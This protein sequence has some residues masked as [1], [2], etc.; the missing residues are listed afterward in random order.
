MKSLSLKS[1]LFTFAFTA[2]GLITNAQNFEGGVRIGATGSTVQDVPLVESRNAPGGI[3]GIY[4]RYGGRFYGELGIMYYNSKTTF[5]EEFFNTSYD[6]DFSSVNVPILAGYNIIDN[7][8]FRLRAFAGGSL[9]FM[10]GIDANGLLELDDLNDFYGLLN[11]GAGVEYKK[12]HFD[13]KYEQAFDD[14]FAIEQGQ[15]MRFT[16]SIGY[17]IF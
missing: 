7:G 6:L 11:I 4:G 3:F 2:L 5:E 1:L 17:R 12:F 15:L 9:Q 10:T 14:F 16:G 13:F 8:D